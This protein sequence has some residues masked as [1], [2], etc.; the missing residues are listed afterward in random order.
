MSPPPSLHGLLLSSLL[1]Y[2]AHC[3]GVYEFSEVEPLAP[4]DRTYITIFVHLIDS[5]SRME[6]FGSWK[7]GDCKLCTF[8]TVPATALLSRER[9]NKC[10]SRSARHKATGSPYGSTSGRQRR[11]SC[12]KSSIP[13]SYDLILS[14]WSAAPAVEQIGPIPSGPHPFMNEAFGSRLI[15]SQRSAWVGSIEAARQAASKHARTAQHPN[16]K[17]AAGRPK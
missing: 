4:T 10:P 15:H 3:F 9:D 6:L 8:G 5:V 12:W 17:S 14:L 11:R 7:H 1:S 13:G 16:S 2:Q